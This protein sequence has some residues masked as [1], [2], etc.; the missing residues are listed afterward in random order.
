M[1]AASAA[2]GGGSGA[3]DEPPVSEI[4][5]RWASA[6]A[7]DLDTLVAASGAVFVGS[8]EERSGQIDKELSAQGRPLPF[9]QYAV[10]VQDVLAGDGTAGELVT[11][12]QLGGVAESSRGPVT[13]VAQGDTQLEPGATYVFFARADEAGVYSAPPFGRMPVVDGQVLAPEGWGSLG[14]VSQMAGLAL[15][16]AAGEVQR[17]R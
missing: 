14:A 8:V 7:A 9:T 12:E 2:C 4:E 5:V 17:A 15:T 10:R 6:M 3:P 11:F 13:L 1:L 16:Q